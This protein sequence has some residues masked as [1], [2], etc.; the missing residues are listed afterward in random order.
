MNRV[1][2]FTKAPFLQNKALIPLKIYD[3]SAYAF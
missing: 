1:K 2:G 3:L